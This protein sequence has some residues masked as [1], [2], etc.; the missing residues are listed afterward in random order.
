MYMKAVAKKTVYH[1][2]KHKYKIILGTP[3][4]FAIFVNIDIATST[5][6]TMSIEST[7]TI[8][9]VVGDTMTIDININTTAQINATG[10]DVIFE[11]IFLA[12]I[13]IST[14]KSIVDLWAQKPTLDKASTTL[15]FAGGITQEKSFTGIGHV[16]S[17][18]AKILAPGK[19][20]ISLSNPKLLASDGVGTNL[21]TKKEDLVLCI[22]KQGLPSPDMNEDNKISLMDVNILYFNTLR[23]DNPRYDL[24]GDG[25]VTLK[26]VRLLISML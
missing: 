6:N 25:K 12:P 14:D 2:K 15:S 1:A 16:F 5:L 3:I 21:L 9:V 22:R 10:G 26:D 24:N 4:L 23:K 19:T 13:S 7:D 17:F 11:D 18:T 20:T 8:F